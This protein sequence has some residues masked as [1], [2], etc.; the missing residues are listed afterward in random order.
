M[1]VE[2]YGIFSGEFDGLKMFEDDNER[3]YIGVYTGLHLLSKEYDISDLE[4]FDYVQFNKNGAFEKMTPRKFK[5]NI[6]QELKRWYELLV[7]DR[8]EQI[9]FDI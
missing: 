7:V 5:E 2:V 3:H 1:I 4:Q 6:E 9:V 8:F